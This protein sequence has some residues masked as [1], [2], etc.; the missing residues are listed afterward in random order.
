MSEAT[1]SLRQR[2]A[3]LLLMWSLAS[4][5]SG[6]GLMLT[7]GDIGVPA[8]LRTVGFHFVIWGGIDLI[9]ALMGLRRDD[10]DPSDLIRILRFNERL[11]YVWVGAG[12]LMIAL[13]VFALGWL[14]H[15]IGTLIQGGFLFWYDRTFRRALERLT[16]P[17][18]SR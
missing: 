5:A 3:R 18:A 7:G 13:S 15:G 2:R 8:V 16:P 6:V 1:G 12:L 9:F 14:G 17:A 4:V 10:G 11:N